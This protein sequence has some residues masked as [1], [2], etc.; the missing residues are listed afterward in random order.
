MLHN[1]TAKYGAKKFKKFSEEFDDVIFCSQTVGSN[2]RR[3][4]FTYLHGVAS[5][6]S[7]LLG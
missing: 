4:I 5:S 2:F 6:N 3:N 1:R 7:Y